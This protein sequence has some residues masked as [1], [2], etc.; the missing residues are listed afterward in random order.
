[1]EFKDK[2]MLHC[3]KERDVSRVSL[4]R[5]Y[6]TYIISI[7][8]TFSMCISG[9]MVSESKFGCSDLGLFPWRVGY[10]LTF[11]FF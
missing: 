3:F 7:S 8:L 5:L 4:Q 6:I 11:Q 10:E 2:I 1:M 9:L